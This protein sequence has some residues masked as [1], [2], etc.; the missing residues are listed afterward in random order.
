MRY[1]CTDFSIDE[2]WSFGERVV[3]HNF[4][5]GPEITIAFTGSEWISPFD[6]DW[7]VSTSFSLARRNDTGEINST[8]R[9]ITSPLLR[10]QEGCNHT[11]TIPVS[12][13]DGDT[14][15]CRWAVGSEC[16]G[17]CDG[18]PGAVLD[19]ESCSLSYYA[20]Q[21]QGYRAAA[22]MIE[23]FLPGSDTP[24]SSVGLQFLVLVVGT[25]RPCS[26]NPTF[27]HPTLLVFG[28]TNDHQVFAGGI[29]KALCCLV[30][31]CLSEFS[32]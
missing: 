13:P 1:R 30:Y 2:D 19:P 12:D 17:I 14:I 6:S 27:V 11:I 4:T 10:F 32:R 28:A 5:R 29:V 22:I 20:N 23:D 26:V 9:A 3:V 21:G 7:R 25:M 8:P 15:Q 18:F 24:M 31:K 16:A